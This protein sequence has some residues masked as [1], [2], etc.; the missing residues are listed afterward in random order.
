MTL[1]QVVDYFIIVESMWTAAA[2]QKPLFLV[3][4]VFPRVGW[5]CRVN[6]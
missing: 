5:V 3:E 4:K 1:N 2:K 6:I